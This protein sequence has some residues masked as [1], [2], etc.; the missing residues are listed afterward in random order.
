[1]NILFGCSELGMRRGSPMLQK[2]MY[3]SC[4]EES[5]EK[6]TSLRKN[7]KVLLMAKTTYYLYNSYNYYYYD[8]DYY[9]Y[10]D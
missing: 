3:S 8:Y 4:Q 1:M 10:Y 5:H 9:Y 6:Q 2:L 7:P